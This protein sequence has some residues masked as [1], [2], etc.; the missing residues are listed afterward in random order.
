MN[1]STKIT[2]AGYNTTKS[3]SVTIRVRNDLNRVYSVTAREG[4]G[5]ALVNIFE[6]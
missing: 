4:R 5:T 1:K 3:N 6:N 2:T